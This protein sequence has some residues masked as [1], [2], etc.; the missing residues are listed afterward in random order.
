MS[1]LDPEVPPAGEEVHLPGPS[2]LPVLTGVGITLTLVG[3]TTFI[4][5]TIIGGILTI[6]CVVRWIK[7]TRHDIDELPLDV[8]VDG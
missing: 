4:E 5:L 3:I 2:I 8:H 1:P 6:G 7:D